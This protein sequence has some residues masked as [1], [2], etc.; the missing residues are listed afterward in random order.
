MTVSAFSEAWGRG[1]GWVRTLA[2]T[3]RLVCGAVVF[4]SCSAAPLN[5]RWGTALFFCVLAGWMVLCGMP[6]RR[7]KELLRFA[8][9]LFFVP[10]F[11]FTPLALFR[12]KEGVFFEAL[13]VALA[14]GLRGTACIIV[15][16]ASMSSL[17]L[18]ELGQG[19]AG[20]RLP[21]PVTALVL[22]IAHQTAL[23]TDEVGR[24]ETALCVRGVTT[25]GRTARL[26]CL[27]AL[28]VIWL[29]R[30]LQR[31][32]RVSAAMEVRG[33]EGAVREKGVDLRVRDVCAMAAALLVFGAILFL[34][35]KTG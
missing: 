10:L 34:R 32:E 35:R 29:L 4:A 23:L 15:C 33:F 20:L 8:F 28:P 16:A 9:L 14:I 22:Q 27:F 3:V 5:G 13:R 26:R 21:G 6:R 31:A 1:S 2:P 30:L 18:S 12:E 19:L 7:L 24:L 11:L 17:E 25:A